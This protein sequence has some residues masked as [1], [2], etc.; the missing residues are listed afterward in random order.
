MATRMSTNSV[1]AFEKIDIKHFLATRM[2]LSNK[3]S[4][5]QRGPKSTDVLSTFTSVLMKILR[6]VKCEMV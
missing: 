5:A 6:L 1:R 3:V 2:R 4:A